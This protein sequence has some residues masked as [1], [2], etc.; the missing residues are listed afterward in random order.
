MHLVDSGLQRSTSNQTLSNAVSLQDTASVVQSL[1]SQMLR[2]MGDKL[3]NSLRASNI[4][5]VSEVGTHE[6]SVHCK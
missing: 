2:M 5:T 4:Q 3:V 1:R 6:L